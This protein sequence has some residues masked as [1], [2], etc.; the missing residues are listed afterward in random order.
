MESG[1]LLDA[2]GRTPLVRVSRA[3]PPS[4][5][6]LLLKLEKWN[7]GGSLRDRVAKFSIE[8]ALRDDR[9]R[10]GGAVVAAAGEDGAFSLALVCAVR[11][12]PL[13]L[14]VP[15]S[16]NPSRR[17]AAARFGARVVVVEGTLDEAR[18]AAAAEAA[19]AGSAALE[20]ESAAVAA[21]AC[22]EIGV[23]ILEATAS[24]T[25]DAFV[26]VMRSTTPG[27]EG[28]LEGIGGVLH[29]RFPAME[30][31]PVRLAGFSRAEADGMVDVALPEARAAALELAV[32]EGLLLGPASGAAFAVARRVAERL[33]PGR[34]VVA[35]CSDAGERH[36]IAAEVP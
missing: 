25:I 22:A 34:R 19:R 29:A 16:T 12:H 13:T 28:T 35:L 7:P 18:N 24:G 2:I 36:L 31:H 14:F 8:Q 23:E 1:Q 20:I 27:G 17:A 4:G 21:R 32:R 26:G 9:L 15:A 3:A 33:G 5:A 6:E 10:P 30:V 11:A